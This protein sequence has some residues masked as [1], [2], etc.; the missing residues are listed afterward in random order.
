MYF[1]LDFGGTNFRISWTKSLDK[2]D[3]TNNTIK[4]KNTGNYEKD[5]LRI[6]NF[7]NSK[8]PKVKG[9]VIALPG[10]F[11]YEKMVLDGA[12]NLK[13]W[14]NKPFFG[15]LKSEFGCDLIV[16]KDSCVAA[17]GEG[18]DNSLNENKFLYIAWGTG[19]GG[20]FVDA[21]GKNLPK[22]TPLDW[23]KTFGRIET[24]CS[25]GHAMANFGVE[26]RHL[27]REQW[28]LLVE[29]FVNEIEKICHNLNLGFVVLGGG[30]TA[31]RG[32]IVSIIQKGLEKRGIKLVKSKLGDFSAIYGGYALLRSKLNNEN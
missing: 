32:N 2:V 4:I 13:A 10:Q 28:D 29:N 22:I 14:I 9:I 17:V 30:I 5:S 26:L 25:G 16:D 11:N 31:R 20:C 8:S 12:N 3:V 21:G 7:M 18:L 15:Q 24:L 19:I 23:K 27:N 6:K 1:V